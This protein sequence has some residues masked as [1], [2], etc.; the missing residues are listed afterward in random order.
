MKNRLVDHLRIGVHALCTIHIVTLSGIGVTTLLTP[1]NI[2]MI[3]FGQFVP[4][5][6]L[7]YP[8]L[9][10]AEK[11]WQYCCVGALIRRIG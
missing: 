5:A 2:Y 8:E 10:L 11:D 1:H 3:W 4:S 9:Y 7:F 6:P